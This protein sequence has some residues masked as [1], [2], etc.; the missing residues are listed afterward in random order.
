MRRPE[1][2]GVFAVGEVFAGAP[3]NKPD[4]YDSGCS[5]TGSTV[6]V[7]TR[8]EVVADGKKIGKAVVAQGRGQTIE[9]DFLGAHV[10]S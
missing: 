9:V 5:S 10:D 8:M 1:Q 7:C 3:A 4:V 6:T 2:G